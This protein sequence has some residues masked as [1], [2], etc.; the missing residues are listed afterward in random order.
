[1]VD[2]QERAL[3][4]RQRIFQIERLGAMPQIV[5]RLIEALGDEMTTPAKI[6]KLI[7][8]DPALASKVLSLANSA[9]YGLAQKVTTIS[10]AVVVMGFDELQ[11][12]AVGAGLADMF[13]PNTLPDLEGESLWRHCLAVSWT[14]KA[15]AETAGYPIPTE[16]MVAGLLHD[17]GKLVLMTHFPEEYRELLVLNR[18]GVPYYQAEEQSGLKHNVVGHWLARRWRLPA[19]HEAAIRNHHQLSGGEPYLFA[20][21]LVALADVLVKE[22]K[23]GLVQEARPLDRLA[24][25]RGA[26]LTRPD[27]ESVAEKARVQVPAM[28]D[29][30]KQ[31]LELDSGN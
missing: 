18:R 28:L 14:A 19:L 8:G 30:W 3:R 29:A 6:E 12:L 7:E 5:W 13:N 4:I 11:I 24:A 2:E 15:L 21:S 26:G 22:L 27:I 9:Y 17:L 16:I 20:T 1:M 23:F 10:R 31:M 25:L